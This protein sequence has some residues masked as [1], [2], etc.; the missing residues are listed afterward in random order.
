M[1]ILLFYGSGGK[2]KGDKVGFLRE[3]YRWEKSSNA[4]ESRIS[5]THL[6]AYFGNGKEN[7]VLLLT[8]KK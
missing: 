7:K 8:M 4:G 3:K 1:Q 6:K 2:P 5:R